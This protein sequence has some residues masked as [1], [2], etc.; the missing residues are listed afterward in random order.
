MSLMSMTKLALRS[1]LS[2]PATRNYPFEV[3]EPFAATRGHILFKV[4]TCNFCTACAKRCPTEAIVVNRKTRLWE[5]DHRKCILCSACI[6]G[7]PKSCISLSNMPAA[8]FDGEKW[9]H[10][11]HDTAPDDSPSPIFSCELGEKPPE[12]KK[13]AP[14][15]TEPDQG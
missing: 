5:I 12:P 9:R 6:D 2:R 8:P 7:C 14:A 13:D 4:D 3:R 1:L 11:E 15:K 10:F